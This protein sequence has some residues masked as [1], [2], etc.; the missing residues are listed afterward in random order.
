MHTGFLRYGHVAVRYTTSDGVSRVMNILGTYDTDGAHMVN[1]VEPSDYIYGTAGWKSFAQQGGAYN[2]DIV[3]VRVERCAPGAIDAMHAYFKALDLKTQIGGASPSDASARFQLVE[4]RL[5]L[6][7]SQL[8]GRLDVL[9]RRALERMRDTTE[10]LSKGTAARSASGSDSSVGG[11]AGAERLAEMALVVTEVRAV[12]WIAGN[13]AQWTSEG[14]VFAGLLRR[15]RLF[16]KSILVELLESEHLR[17]GRT[18]NAHVVVYK[19]IA[20][21]PPYLPGY[22]FMAPAY[23]HPLSPMRNFVYNDMHRFADV[24]V[25]VAPGE[26]EAAVRHNAA[27]ARPP[28]WMP[29]WRAF[30]LG[31]PTAVALGAVDHIGPMGP[32]VAGGWLV[33]NWWLY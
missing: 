32:A 27:P 17:H 20:H 22:R 25:E 15:S 31:A 24:L 30:V 12:Q 19:H 1:F 33:L 3:G 9:L 26:T 18:K 4:A 23:V 5:S 16:P 29:Y 11:S 7:A 13:C 8:P 10:F 2:R 14:I 6:V 21:A 28:L